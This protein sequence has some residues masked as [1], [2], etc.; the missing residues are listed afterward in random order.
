[1]PTYCE[2]QITETILLLITETRLLKTDPTETEEN[3]VETPEKNVE[4]PKPRG[5]KDIKLCTETMFNL[6]EK[7]NRKR[8]NDENNKIQKRGRPSRLDKL[9]EMSI[10]PVINDFN[11]FSTNKITFGEREINNYL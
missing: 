8:K 2:A 3:N 10:S 5:K 4:T 6:K 7:I 11:N 9:A 1:M